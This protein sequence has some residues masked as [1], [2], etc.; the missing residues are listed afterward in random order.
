M[1]DQSKFSQ[2]FKAIEDFLNDD[3]YAVS[4]VGGGTHFGEH[5]FFLALQA[6]S[7]LRNSGVIYNPSEKD[8]E[9]AE[10]LEVLAQNTMLSNET[11]TTLRQSANRLKGEFSQ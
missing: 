2:L 10:R 4:G 7:E 1:T 8:F 11:R 3:R 6:R 5:L 9:L